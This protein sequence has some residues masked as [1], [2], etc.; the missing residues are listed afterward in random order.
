[1]ATTLKL[2]SALVV[3]VCL[4]AIFPHASQGANHDVAMVGTAFSP[5]TLQILV[6]DNVTWQNNAVLIHTTTSGNPDRCNG[7]GIWNSGSMV[8]GA[9]FNVVFNTSGSFQYFCIPHCLVGMR[10]TIIVNP[11][12]PVYKST[13]GAIK[14]LYAVNRP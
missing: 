14:A 12:V 7:D 2:I 10:G 9:T 1:M 11:P 3:V 13:W 4:I 5:T 8:P 6:G